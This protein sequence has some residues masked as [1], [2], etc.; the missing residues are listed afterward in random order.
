[1]GAQHAT[2]VYGVDYTEGLQHPLRVNPGG[3]LDVALQDQTT[4]VFYMRALIEEG[5]FTLATDVTS[6]SYSFD[7]VAGHGITAGTSKYVEFY[8]QTRWMQ[9]NVIDV[10]D[11]TITID[12]PF[13]YTYE[14]GTTVC[15]RGDEDLAVDGSGTA[16][17]S[18]ITNRDLLVDWDITRV[19]VY[20]Q[21]A[22][23]MDHSTFGNLGALTRGV[24]WRFQSDSGV[25]PLFNGYNAKTNGHLA[26][27][28]NTYQYTDK[29]GGGEYSFEGHK[30]LGGQSNLGVVIR[31]EVVSADSMQVIIQDDLTDLTHFHVHFEG[32]IVLP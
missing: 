29:A 4:P 14:S 22:A 28:L 1:M 11:D 7:A 25:W 17:V 30:L 12:Q 13:D 24:L 26:E 27:I 19:N 8:N 23:A 31:L 18:R 20:I 5:T 2:Q 10:T 21:D 9:A 3:S 16:V 15:Y 32:S 6:G